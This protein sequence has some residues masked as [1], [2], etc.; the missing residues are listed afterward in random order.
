M[1]AM[2][3]LSF[4]LFIGVCEIALSQILLTESA[5]NATDAYRCC[6]SRLHEV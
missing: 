5:S 4:V 6:I 2:R 1:L 3:N